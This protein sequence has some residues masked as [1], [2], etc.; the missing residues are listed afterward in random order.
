MDGTTPEQARAALDTVERSRRQVIDEIAVPAWYWAS[1]A[2]GWILL[3]VLADLDRPWLTTAA[4][5]VFGAGHATIAPRV[6]DGRHGNR[7]MSVR[8]ELA[9]RSLTRLVIGGLVAAVVLTVA[10]ALAL[11]ADG[12]R[13]PS[14][15]ASVFV[16]AVVGLGG[17]LLL[18]TVRRRAA[19]D[20]HQVVG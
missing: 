17:P 18:A 10:A 5:L 13:H 11:D 20:R 3:G 15:G 9:G 4:T 14:I 2:G 12:A 16:A 8:A 1:L 7:Q 6:I 19:R